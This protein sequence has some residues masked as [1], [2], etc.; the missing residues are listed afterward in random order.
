MAR[1]YAPVMYFHKEE[2]YRPIAI[3][4]P[5]FYSELGKYETDSDGDLK[6][7]TIVS[8]PKVSDLLENNGSDIYINFIGNSADELKKTYDFFKANAD[9]VAYTRVYCP[10]SPQ[11][12]MSSNIKLVIQYWFFYYDNPWH[13][14]HEGDWEMIQVMIDE[15]N[16]PV[17]GGYSQHNAGSWRPWQNIEIEDETHP[18]VYVAKDGHPSYFSEGIYKAYLGNNE[19]NLLYGNDV[20]KPAEKFGVIE[21]TLMPVNDTSSWLYFDGHWGDKGTGLLD[22]DA[23]TGPRRRI[24]IDLSEITS[25]WLD[26][27]E[28]FE[29]LDDDAVA[30]HNT[31]GKINVSARFPIE[32]TFTVTI[33]DTDNNTARSIVTNTIDSEYIDNPDTGRRTLIIHEPDPEAIYSFEFTTEVSASLVSDSSDIIVHYPDFQS[34]ESIVT[35]YQLPDEWT[36]DSNAQLDLHLQ[37]DYNLHVD[38]DNDGSTDQE[39][40]PSNQD[41]VLF[42]TYLPVILR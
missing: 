12:V 28:W 21:T 31:R 13:S 38:V 11:P 22:K 4:K 37:S 35:E 29:R 3:D 41:Q 16:K 15:D 7:T 32:I 26:P 20:A 17:Y 23:P 5:L 19:T 33:S 8:R 40:P 42:E 34:D 14:R 18:V 36:S 24:A 39:L 6:F 1:L 30:S 25:L 2:P 9:K 10:A 27:I